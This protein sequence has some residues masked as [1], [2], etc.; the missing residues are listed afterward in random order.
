[1]KR[2]RAQNIAYYLVPSV[3]SSCCFFLFT[4][5]D[6]VFVG[7]G[8]GVDALGAINIALPFVMLVVSL[9]LL[10]TIGG[11]TIAA[12]RLGRG[13]TN[14][15]NQVF[16]HALSGIFMVAVLLCIAGMFFTGPLARL[17]GANDIYFTYVRDYLF[18]YSAFLIISEPGFLLQAF[19]RN[20]GSPRLVAASVIVSTAANVFLDWLFIFPLQQGVAGTA[21]A[22]GISQTI[23]AVIMLSHFI[24][25]K[26][27][28][29][30]HLFT[31]D[32]AMWRK[33]LLR[34]LPE[35]TAQFAMPVTTLCL[36]YTLLNSLGASAVNAYSII[37]YVSSCLF[38]AFWGISEG[39]QP[40]FGQ[41]YG[42]KKENDLKYY[43]HAGVVINFSASVAI[44]V[45]LLFLGRVI[46]GL[47]GADETIYNVIVDAMPKFA[48]SFIPISLTA[49]ISAYLYSTK[50]TKESVIINVCRGLLF[51]SVIISVFPVLFGVAVV[52]FTA[53]IA[54]MLA[55]IVAITL[56][57]RSEKNGI[58]FR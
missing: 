57:K 53:G 28:L 22:T 20:D 10:V 30:F 3:L 34:G 45:L 19:C 7:R 26:G 18:W 55:L 40:L 12:I 4:V 54:E 29:R 37:N 50:R 46:C 44:F 2:T 14:G 41:S 24:R 16:M 6:G 13:D 39:L 51:N 33:I 25:K 49:I 56:L 1:M 58:T 23:G 48:W 9:N 31:P 36:N 21:I 11:V 47:F 35:M 5:I 38:A 42:A 8:V 27:A 17:L 32:F 43:F 15:A 52:W